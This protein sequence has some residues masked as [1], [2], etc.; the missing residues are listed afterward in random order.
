MLLEE[1]ATDSNSSIIS[2]LKQ[3]FSC[4]SQ[5]LTLINKH[6]NPANL[7]T[8]SHPSIVTVS[9]ILPLELEPF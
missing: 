8:N 5:L 2:K 1:I 3:I 7:P 6:L 4:S 9:E